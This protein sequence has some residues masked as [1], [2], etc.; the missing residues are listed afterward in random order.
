MSPEALIYLLLAHFAADFPLQFQSMVRLRNSPD[1]RAS[2]L[3]NALHAA[4]HLML[5][6]F[7]VVFLRSLKMLFVIIIIAVLHFA[8]D[9]AKSKAILKRPF[10]KYSVYL[11]LL[12]QIMHVTCICLVFFTIN[13]FS[14][15]L[16]AKALLDAIFYSH[17]YIGR[18]MVSMIILIIGLWGTGVF[19]RMVL[20]RMN[21]LPY[22]SAINLKISLASSNKDQGAADGGYLIG[23]LE[24][25]FIIISIIL[26]MP[27]VIGFILTVKSVARLKKFDDERFVEIFIIGSFISFISAIIAGCVISRLHIIPPL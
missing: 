25:F 12:D 26:N 7:S 21:L 22:K 16:P 5:S 15:G 14:S 13:G 17:T 4:V 9:L 20:D 6:L 2:L 1:R 18:L 3:G 8:I 23:I 27:L 24:R 10:I 19:I 11:F